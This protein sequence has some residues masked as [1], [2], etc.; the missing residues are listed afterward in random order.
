MNFCCF[1]SYFD[2]H[3]GF[4][5]SVAFQRETTACFRESPQLVSEGSSNVFQGYKQH[6]LGSSQLFSVMLPARIWGIRNAVPRDDRK[7][8]RGTHNKVSEHLEEEFSDLESQNRILRG[9]GGGSPEISGANRLEGERIDDLFYFSTV[10]RSGK[11]T[12]KTHFFARQLKG[13]EYLAVGLD[14]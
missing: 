13:R 1:S 6:V 10:H 2:N 12:E 11:L 3:R 8:F 4:G 9:S 5:V 7:S 14:L